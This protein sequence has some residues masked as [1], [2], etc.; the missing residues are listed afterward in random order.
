MMLF[1]LIFIIVCFFITIIR[2]EYVK[3]RLVRK[4]IQYLDEQNKKNKLQEL[5]PHKWGR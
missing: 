3:Y 1:T 5:N 2:Y 4:C